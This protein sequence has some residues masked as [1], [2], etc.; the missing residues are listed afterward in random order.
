MDLAI[1]FVV[2]TLTK[3]FW[4][5]TTPVTQ[6]PWGCVME[7]FKSSGENSSVENISWNDCQEFIRRLNEK[8]KT[9]GYP[10]G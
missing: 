2:F 7:G 9:D 3:G 5:Q 8:E 10:S 6:K 1:V 4:I